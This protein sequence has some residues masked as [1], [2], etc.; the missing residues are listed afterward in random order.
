MATARADAKL[1]RLEARLG[2]R[3]YDEANTESTALL[4]AGGGGGSHD[5]KLLVLRA[6]ILSAQGNPAGA[7]KHA[8]VRAGGREEGNRLTQAA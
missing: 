4:K 6:R 2:L 1:A 8:Q 5:P 7:M 3:A